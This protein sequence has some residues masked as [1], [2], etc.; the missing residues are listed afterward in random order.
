[1]EGGSA[2][3][4]VP[5]QKEAKEGGIRVYDMIVNKKG[6]TEETKYPQDN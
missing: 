3:R 2:G 4:D 5:Q 6:G 1:M